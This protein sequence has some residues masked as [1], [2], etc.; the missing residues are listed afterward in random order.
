MYFVLLR[1]TRLFCG[2][3]KS[4]S[5]QKKRMEIKNRP[6]REMSSGLQIETSRFLWLNACNY[7]I[8]SVHLPTIFHAGYWAAV[9]FVLFSTDDWMTSVQRA[10]CA[11]WSKFVE[12][13]EQFVCIGSL[14][15]LFSFRRCVF[16]LLLLFARCFARALYFHTQNLMDALI[17]LMQRYRKKYIYI[18]T[19]FF[20]L[21]HYIEI[22]FRFAFRVVFAFFFTLQ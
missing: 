19:N 15:V 2:Q 14:T 8:F 21:I 16:L 5:P 22:R 12:I 13:S 17:R 4:K 11:R 1:K 3:E 20:R 10:L 9:W 7:L 6:A 18:T